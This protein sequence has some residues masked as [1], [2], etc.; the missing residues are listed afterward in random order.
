MAPAACASSSR[1]RSPPPGLCAKKFSARHVGQQHLLHRRAQPRVARAGLVQKLRPQVRIRDIATRRN[2]RL[3][4]LGFR[5]HPF[6]SL[7]P[8]EQFDLA[9][10]H[11]RLTVRKLMPSF[12]PPPHWSARRKISATQS[13]PFPDLPSSHCNASSISRICSSGVAAVISKSSIH[14]LLAA[15]MFQGGFAPR[16][17]NQDAP[18]RVRRR[19][20]KMPRFFQVRSPAPTSCSH[21]SCTS[22][23]GCNVWPAASLA[24]RAAASRRN[25]S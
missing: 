13:A 2:T 20:K 6:C 4:Q 5:A 16:V 23:V 14:A 11:W 25:S 18:H 8:A 10:I 17:V 7:N 15:A 12:P 3:F 1:H 24:I 21:A 9:R 22:A 19:A